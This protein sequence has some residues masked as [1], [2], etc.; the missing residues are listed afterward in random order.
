MPGQGR[1]AQ[2]AAKV[3]GSVPGQGHMA[4]VRGSVRELPLGA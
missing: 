2:C 4:K 1:V 3:R